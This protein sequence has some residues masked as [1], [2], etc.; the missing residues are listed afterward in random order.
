MKQ[1]GMHTVTEMSVMLGMHLKAQ[2]ANLTL[3]NQG[4]FLETV[5]TQLCGTT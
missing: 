5:T 1:C 4:G 3:D 2:T